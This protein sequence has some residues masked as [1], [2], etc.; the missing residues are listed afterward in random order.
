MPVLN[1]GNIRAVLNRRGW[2]DMILRTSGG[3]IDSID[4][5]KK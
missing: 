1:H 4:I 2:K 3:A 5:Y